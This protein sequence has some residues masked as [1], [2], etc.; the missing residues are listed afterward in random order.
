MNVEIREFT[1]GVSLG[2]HIAG[3]TI[4]NA[5]VQKVY[6][7]R[8]HILIDGRWV[9]HVGWDEG[10]QVCLCRPVTEAERQAIMRKC[11]EEF[12]EPCEAVMA[13]PSTT[14]PRDRRR[15]RHKAHGEPSDE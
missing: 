4:D 5:G 6:A 15:R 12:G 8:S 9:G 7:R 10:E 11:E 3:K 2:D 14:E 13:S 1:A